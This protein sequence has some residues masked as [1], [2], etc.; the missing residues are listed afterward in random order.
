ERRGKRVAQA[1]RAGAVLEGAE[2]QRRRG[3]RLL[4]ARQQLD[5]LQALARR[6][7]DDVDA[8]LEDV[9]LVEQHEARTSAPEQGGEHLLEVGV[10][11]RERLLEALTRGLVDAVNRLAR[12]GHGVD[13]SLALA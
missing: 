8:A 13:E 1:E 12:G 11:C 5:V 7:R 4:A 3:Q 6:L 10:D 2:H 9:L